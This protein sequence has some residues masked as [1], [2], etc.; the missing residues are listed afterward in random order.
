M[1]KVRKVLNTQKYH[2]SVYRVTGS[3]VRK[4]DYFFYLMYNEPENKVKEEIT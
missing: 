4:D 2:Y 3:V 1:E